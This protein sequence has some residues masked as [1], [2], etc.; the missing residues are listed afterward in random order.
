MKT[1]PNPASR[2]AGIGEADPSAAIPATVVV[3]T[4]DAAAVLPDCLAGLGRFSQVLVVDSES[5]D[6]TA[7]LARFHA[8]ELVPFRWDRRYP[9]KKQWCLAHPSVRH[10]LVLFVDAD[11]RLP[12]EAVQEI[13][14]IATA[15]TRRCG[16][17]SAVL[18]PVLGGRVLRFGRAHRK[19]VL[20]D[21]RRC[22]FGTVDDLDAPC[23]GEVEG[24]YQP[25]V[26]GPVGRLRQTWRH[27]IGPL[28]DWREKHRRYART[29]GWLEATGRPG[30]PADEA[31]PW[32]RR[33]IKRALAVVP[34]R[35]VLAFLD[36]WVLRLGMLDGRAG[37]DWA[38]MRAWYYRQIG[39]ECRRYRRKAPNIAGECASSVAASGPAVP[40]SRATARLNR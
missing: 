29:A 36:S 33:W 32:R 14:R 38:V 8:A 37:L 13:G 30:V 35:A 31:Q 5:R 40:P 24:H 10:D 34:G 4:R 39:R 6:D 25:A 27:E 12:P 18:R 28:G 26:D 16:A 1:V 3:M 11:E 20:L 19:I 7:A 23:T 21:R 17:W 15:E 2:H 22:R 9:K